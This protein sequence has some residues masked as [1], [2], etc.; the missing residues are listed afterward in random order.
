MADTIVHTDRDRTNDSA[1]GWFVGLIAL[2]AL[3]IGGILWYRSATPGIPNTG[4]DINVTIPVPTDGG[5][6][7][8]I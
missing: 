6:T 3:V 7:D 2:L 5:G 8:G 1:V 4:D